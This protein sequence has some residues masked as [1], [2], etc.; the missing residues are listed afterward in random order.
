VAAKAP[1]SPA[2]TPLWLR[3]DRNLVMALECEAIVASHPYNAIASQCHT[4]YRGHCVNWLRASGGSS[5]SSAVRYVLVTI[6]WFTVVVELGLILAEVRTLEGLMRHLDG[7]T[8]GIANAM[9][10]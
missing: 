1:Y 9:P 2:F 10:R 3:V 4:R 5:M 7:V 8:A 6:M